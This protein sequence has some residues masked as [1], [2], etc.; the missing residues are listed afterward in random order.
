MIQPNYD[1]KSIVPYSESYALHA[2]RLYKAKENLIKDTER[3]KRWR[4]CLFYKSRYKTY[5]FFLSLFFLLSIFSSCLYFERSYYSYQWATN[6]VEKFKRLGFSFSFFIDYFWWA[7][8]YRLLSFLSG[9]TIFA[10]TTVFLCSCRTFFSSSFLFLIFVD[11]M[12]FKGLSIVFLF[13][14]LSAFLA[15]IDIVFF[16]ETIKF[17]SSRKCNY[18]AHTAF[19]YCMMFIGYLAVV[20]FSIYLQLCLLISV[21]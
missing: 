17:N 12:S 7:L 3:T 14:A 20:L 1:I 2:T 21:S 19:V 6:V 18:C 4:V 13:V 5:I 15:F 16:A 10:F 11:Y 8:A 9:F